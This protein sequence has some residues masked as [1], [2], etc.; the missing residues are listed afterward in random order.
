MK[1][2]TL[3]CYICAFLV[4]YA[5][6]GGLMPIVGPGT[7]LATLPVCALLWCGLYQAFV[8]FHSQR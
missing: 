6:S 4:F 3:R 8:T 7:L 5:F 2:A 1:K